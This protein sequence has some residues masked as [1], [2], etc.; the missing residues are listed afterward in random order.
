MEKVKENL[1]IEVEALRTAQTKMVEGKERE[2]LELLE[3]IK[4][5]MYGL[6]KLT[7]KIE[8]LKIQESNEECKDRLDEIMRR[9]GNN[10]KKMEWTSNQ[11]QIQMKDKILKLL[12]KK[13][14]TLSIF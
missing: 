13:K 6:A 3:N 1:N 4:V 14:V 2:G 12:G 9:T 10:I 8:N 11:K 7:G 5:N